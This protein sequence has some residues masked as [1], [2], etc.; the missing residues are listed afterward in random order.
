MVGSNVVDELHND[1]SL[2]DTST[3]EQPNLTTLGIR[4]EKIHNLNTSYKNLLRLALLSE[5]GGSVVD[6]S[7]DLGG[8]GA[9]LI[10]GLT[11][12]VHNA[13]KSLRAHRNQD[14][15][16][17]VLALLATHKTVSRVHG[18]GSHHILTQMLG[19]L[20][21]KSGTVLADSYLQRVKNRGRLAVELDIN[22]G[23]DNLGDPSISPQGGRGFKPTSQ[24]FGLLFDG[25]P[26]KAEHILDVKQFVPD[27]GE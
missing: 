14:G 13:A 12:N 25:T 11:N 17:G 4:G 1:N 2:A 10:N 26:G 7:L 22:D 21:N 3:A 5:E 19:H 23:T 27:S 15:L 9:A 24:T 8:D 18:N 16:A 20:E 6:R